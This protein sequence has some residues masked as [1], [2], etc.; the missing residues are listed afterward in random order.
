MSW[1]QWQGEVWPTTP[2]EGELRCFI[3]S[4]DAGRSR[5]HWRLELMH[6][7]RD[8]PVVPVNYDND[9][10]LTVDIDGLDL[11]LR[12]WRA[13][14]G[15]EIKA[16]AAWHEANDCFGECAHFNS[17][18]VVVSG[19]DVPDAN[20]GI[21]HLYWEGHDFILRFG[22]RDGLWFPCELDAWVMPR[23]EYDRL[24][25]EPSE[26]LERFGEGPPNLRVMMR[27]KFDGGGVELPRLPGDPVAEARRVLREELR[28]EEFYEEKLQWDLR[29]TPDGKEFERLPGGRSSVTY[30][31]EPWDRSQG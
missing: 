6:L 15:L 17:A 19:P 16:D 23:E 7:V 27:V 12:D 24:E 21:D 26:A 9:R 25:P 22:A 18:R 2:D 13:V 4:P 5:Q 30:W 31:S 10:W 14:A 20:G 11:N 8:K 1:V 3:A 28:C 29:R